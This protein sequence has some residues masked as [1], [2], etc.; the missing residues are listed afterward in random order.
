MHY[1]AADFGAGSGRVMVGNLSDGKLSLEEIHRFPNRQIKAGN[2][3]YWDFLSLLQELKTG[4]EL[5]AKKYKDIAGIGI[6]T[7]GVDFGLLDEKGNLLGNPV[8][9]GTGV[10]PV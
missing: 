3:F 10:W 1:I 6:D 8:A 7:W 2:H 9:I 4:I 5:A